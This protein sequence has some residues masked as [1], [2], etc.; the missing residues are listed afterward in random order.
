MNFDQLYEEDLEGHNEAKLKFLVS[1][2]VLASEKIETM[3]STK[4]MIIVKRGALWGDDKKLI[5][6]KKM[7]DK[8][9][10]SEFHT[11]SEKWEPTRTSCTMA[12]EFT[13]EKSFGDGVFKSG[14]AIDYHSASILCHP[15]TL[16]LRLICPDIEETEFIYISTVNRY[17]LAKKISES[18][19]YEWGGA[20]RR[21]R[22]S[23]AER[24]MYLRQPNM[25]RNWRPTELKQWLKVLQ[26]GL[27][28]CISRSCYIDL[29]SQSL[30][31]FEIEWLVIWLVVTATKK[32]PDVYL[33][34]NCE[35]LKSELIRRK[36]TIKEAIEMLRRLEMF[37]R[38]TS[39]NISLSDYLLDFYL[40]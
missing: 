31:D 25:L 36:T 24:Y 23:Y 26:G 33:Q 21:E 39:I 4:N 10:I 22:D 9:L 3:D 17:C 11:K 18:R 38:E 34:T 14:E 35:E 19:G 32:K 27:N 29:N 16:I 7:L 6:S 2:F 8:V 40:V 12:I 20:T 5:T 37:R 15:E 28:L 13:N 1:Y 30:G